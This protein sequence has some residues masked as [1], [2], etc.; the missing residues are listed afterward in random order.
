M[1]ARMKNKTLP[2]AVFVAILGCVL[3][4]SANVTTSKLKNLY[5]TEQY[6]RLTA[7]QELQK[8]QGYIAQ[9]HA[10]LKASKDKLGSIES[11]LTEGKSMT[12][13]MSSQIEQLQQERDT[14]KVKVD[15]LIK[16]QAAQPAASGN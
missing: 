11:I 15:E 14:L 1:E 10:D 13:D 12:K 4:V 6:K 3:A 16:A 8:A 2:V 5:D 7:E 9:L